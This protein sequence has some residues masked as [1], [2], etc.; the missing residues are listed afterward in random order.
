MNGYLL[1]TGVLL[2]FMDDPARLSAEAR[3]ILARPGA[4]I[5]ASAASF[6][7]IAV[8]KALKKTRVPADLHEAVA[9]SGLEIL[10]ILPE[11]AWKTVRLPYQNTDPYDRL[12]IAQALADGLTILTASPNFIGYGIPV[13][14]A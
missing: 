14:K 5:M 10:P 12:L 1:D 2:A 9:A 3:G 13:I 7:E 8:K 4:R 6:L 11:H